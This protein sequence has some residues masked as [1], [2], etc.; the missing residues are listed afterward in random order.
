MWSDADGD[1]VQDAGE[2]GLSG[3]T[4]R[5]YTDANGNGMIDSGEPSVQTTTGPDGSY[6]FSVAATGTQ[7][8]IVYVDP[9]QGS[10]RR[11]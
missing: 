5:L 10:A 4:V 6:Q 11:L 8:Y 9:A 7:D 3:V 2:P 1:G